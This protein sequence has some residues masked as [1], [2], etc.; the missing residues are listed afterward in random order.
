MIDIS[1]ECWQARDLEPGFGCDWW[2]IANPA[3]SN[4]R[5]R[6]PNVGF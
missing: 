3:V 5:L 4:K 1:P 6:M 2:R